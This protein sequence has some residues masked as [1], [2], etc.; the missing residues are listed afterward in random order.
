MIVIS[1]RAIHSVP[2][3]LP[4]YAFAGIVVVP[5]GLYR[6]K[7]V[8]EY[9][10]HGVKLS[11]VNVLAF[12]CIELGISCVGGWKKGQ[13]EPSSIKKCQHVHL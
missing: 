9:P 2:H 6:G 1:H 3:S 7:D 5:R 8:L 11:Q 10:E 13:L 4:C 12:F